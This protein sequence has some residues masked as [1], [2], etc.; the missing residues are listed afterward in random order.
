MTAVNSA[1]TGPQHHTAHH[2]PPWSGLSA[3]IADLQVEVVVLRQ[4]VEYLCATDP[5]LSEALTAW[6]VANK[7]E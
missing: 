4:M 2:A 1:W 6:K 5:K 3:Q 7:L